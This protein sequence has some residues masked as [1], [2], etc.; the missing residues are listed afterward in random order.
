MPYRAVN[1]SP[2]DGPIRPEGPSPS[3]IYDVVRQ[4]QAEIWANRLRLGSVIWN[5]GPIDGNPAVL[6]EAEPQEGFE[7]KV[8]YE[9]APFSTLMG[10]ETDPA[11]QQAGVT[12]DLTTSC[13]EFS[14]P[15]WQWMEV[16]PIHWPASAAPPNGGTII[17]VRL[18]LWVREA[19]VDIV[20]LGGNH[21]KTCSVTQSFVTDTI[22]GGD[23]QVSDYKGNALLPPHR[24][25]TLNPGDDFIVVELS[26][27]WAQ[28]GEGRDR[29]DINNNLLRIGFRSHIST[30]EP[31]PSPV[32]NR[33]GKTEGTYAPI[34][35]ENRNNFF[36]YE[37]STIAF[38]KTVSG[39]DAGW[40]DVDGKFHGIVRLPI[41]IGS[42]VGGN[43]T[44]RLVDY[45][46]V[47]NTS[48]IRSGEPYN[49]MFLDRPIEGGIQNLWKAFS[50]IDPANYS[51]YF[52]IQRLGY[53]KLNWIQIEEVPYYPS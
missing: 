47:A 7:Q 50:T 28:I 30:A 6:A 41:D 22:G 40:P 36:Q 33:V 19:P 18:G 34:Q 53:V 1:L 48:V 16:P 32:M 12:H 4:N 10:W 27:G 45:Y 14:T 25:T 2:T 23:I 11:H 39:Y 24:V 35:T 31:N 20:F 15:P 17:K 37:H 29:Q 52:R 46:V 26:S 3:F 51:D 42:E 21:S 43:S 5:A 13:L 8:N 44:L 38:D 49:L 9:D